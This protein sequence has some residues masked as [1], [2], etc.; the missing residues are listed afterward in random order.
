M[1]DKDKNV[2]KELGIGEASEFEGLSMSELTAEER[3]LD[4]ELKRAELAERLENSEE[5]KRKKRERKE[6]FEAAMRALGLELARRRARQ[7]GCSHRK[8]GLASREG[9]P[10]EGGNGDS[11]ALLKHQLP[12]GDWWVTCQRCAAEW[13]PEDRFTGRPATV[14]GGFTYKDALMAP[15][16]NSPS[17][18][19]VFRLEDQRSPEQKAAQAWQPPR[20]EK[21]ELVQDELAALPGDGPLQPPAPV[22]RRG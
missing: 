17:K 16:D 10:V 19:C 9:L 13:Y 15:T 7:K 20:N 4:V 21:G 2:L 22:L 12:S 8:G 5:R 11:Y 6:Q 3:R 1:S 18:S 14:I